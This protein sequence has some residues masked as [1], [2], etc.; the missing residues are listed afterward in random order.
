MTEGMTPE[1]TMPLVKPKKSAYICHPLRGATGKQG[2]ISENL[3]K[4]DLICK[5]LAKDY[6][7]VLV[8]SP[9][10]AFGFYDP[11][12]CQ[13]Q[14]LGQ[15]V[16]LLEMCDEL[17]VFGDFIESRGCRMEISHAIKLDKPVIYLMGTP[18]G[19]AGE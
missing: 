4:I 7:D 15:C 8:L 12:G 18:F 5:Q 1:M 2:E 16:A 6:P 14:V 13:K 17:W 9:L 3:R 19:K 10:H 11:Q